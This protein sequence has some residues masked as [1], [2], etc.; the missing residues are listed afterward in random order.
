M[1]TRR[2]A[3]AEGISPMSFY[4]HVPSK[5]ELHDLMLNHIA[6]PAT[7]ALPIGSRCIGAQRGPR[8]DRPQR[9]GHER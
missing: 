3:D 4:T 8:K 9:H 2:V 1:R 7:V 5:A 6:A